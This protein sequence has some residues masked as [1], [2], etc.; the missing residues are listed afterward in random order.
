MWLILPD[1]G[2][3]AGIQVTS[4]RLSLTTTQVL[5]LI[6]L[7]LVLASLA[8]PENAHNARDEMADLLCR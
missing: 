2:S 7:L 3:L 8:E 1:E 4:Y 6:G 5:R